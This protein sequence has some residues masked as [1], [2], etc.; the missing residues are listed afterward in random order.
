MSTWEYRVVREPIEKGGAL[1]MAE[2]YYL[3]KDHPKKIT[4]WCWTGSPG[5]LTRDEMLADLR[6]MTAAAERGV[7]IIPAN[8]LPGYGEGKDD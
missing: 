4:A 5:G 7:R 1:R 3:D 2:V 8:E 6:V